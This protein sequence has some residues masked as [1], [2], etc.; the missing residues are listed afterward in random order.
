[1]NK[2]NQ[3]SHLNEFQQKKKKIITKLGSIRTVHEL[4]IDFNDNKILR[5]ALG[6]KT[7]IIYIVP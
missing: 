4:S 6:V 3:G 2:G 1:M 5:K 7:K